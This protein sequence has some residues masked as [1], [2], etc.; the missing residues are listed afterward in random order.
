LRARSDIQFE[1]SAA[2]PPEIPPWMRWLARQLGEVAP[3]MGWVL[4]AC[5][6]IGAAIILYLVVSSLIRARPSGD[7]EAM[8]TRD[9]AAWRPSEKAARALLADAEALAAQ[10][11]YEEAVHL[12]LQRSLEDTGAPRPGPAG[13]AP[14]AGGI[15]GSE[16]GPGVARRAFAAVAG[17]VE[18]S[19][20]GGRSRAR[21]DGEEARAAYGEFALPG[22]WR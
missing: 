17:R 8:A 18:R 10:G 21:A 2:K 19:L 20:F 16:G 12:L 7:A 11:R 13:P 22:A 4:L 15:A 9:V 6:V 14:P 5:V 1:M 3:Y